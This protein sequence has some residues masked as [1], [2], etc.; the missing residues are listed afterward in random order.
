MDRRTYLIDKSRELERGALLLALGKNV[1]QIIPVI[2][3]VDNPTAWAVLAMFDT[4]PE[5]QRKNHTSIIMISD[6]G[7]LNGKERLKTFSIHKC[8]RNPKTT[9]ESPPKF[10]PETRNCAKLELAANIKIITTYNG[11]P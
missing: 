8:P 5:R 7:S 9:P 1:A 10:G 3:P 6:L 2:I 4:I 11:G